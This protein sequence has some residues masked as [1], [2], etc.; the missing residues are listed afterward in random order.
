M[1]DTLAAAI[2]CPG[3]D[4]VQ[5]FRRPRGVFGDSDSGHQ[6][7][8]RTTAMVSIKAADYIL[9]YWSSWVNTT[10]PYSSYPILLSQILPGL[11]SDRMCRRFSDIHAGTQDLCYC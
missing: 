7:P 1:S 8:D 11:V 5:S 4:N 10:D 6:E 3:A 9:S 2:F